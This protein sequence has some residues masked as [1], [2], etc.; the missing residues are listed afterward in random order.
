M[1]QL[2]SLRLP[3]LWKEVKTEEQFWGELKP[4]TRQYLKML[5]EGIL[6]EEQTRSLAAPWHARKVS[7]LDYRNGF[8]VRSIESSLGL[9]ENIKV[10]RNRLTNI[11]FSLFKKYRRKEVA[12]VELIKD[13]FLA[14]LST[15][16]VGEVLEVVLGYKVSATTVSNIAKSLDSAVEA[17]HRKAIDDSYKYL[18]LDGITL[19]VKTLCGV[20]KK[21]VLVACGITDKGVKEIIS[22]RLAP[23]ESEDSWFS[24]VN[25]LYR[26]GL[27]G[28]NLELIVFDGSSSLRRAVDIVYPYNP[29]QRCWVHKLRNI[30]SKLP[31]KG[32]KGVMDSAKKIYLADTRKD[33]EAAFKNWVKDYKD[34][35]PNAVECLSKDIE[36]MLT[37]FYFDEDI[38]SKI[39]TTNLIE[40]SFREIRRRVRPM[41]CFQNSAS[42]NRIIFGVISGINKSWKSRP[43][44]E[45][46]EITQNT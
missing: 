28:K 40:R 3:D 19:K 7:R 34:K 25:D 14:G 2:T 8:Y 15:R 22:F 10:P 11:E 31:K 27:A 35:Y 33:A 26:R 23:G 39:R 32:T 5:I 12:L 24:F 42:V 1:K 6:I 30:A 41:S 4:E 20:V 18:F 16:K 37:C 44:K 45:V 9:L 36:D 21:T 46:K 29:K 43:I 38:R 17:F 13:A